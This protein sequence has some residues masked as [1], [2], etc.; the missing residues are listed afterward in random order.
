MENYDPFF[1]ENLISP[2]KIED[3]APYAVSLHSVYSSMMLTATDNENIT[4]LKNCN[5]S[6]DFIFI[7]YFN[8]YVL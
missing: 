1:L 8:Y 7:F 2:G 4:S 5:H 6:D 3:W